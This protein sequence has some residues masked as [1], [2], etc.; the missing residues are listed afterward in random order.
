MENQAEKERQKLIFVKRKIC[1]KQR[2]ARLGVTVSIYV[3]IVGALTMK[4]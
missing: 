3:R 2:T 4:P 1:V